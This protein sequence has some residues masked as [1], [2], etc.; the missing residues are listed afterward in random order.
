MKRLSLDLVFG[1]VLALLVTAVPVFAADPID[2]VFDRVPAGFDSWQTL[3]SGATT[4]SFAHDPLPA[5]FFCAGSKAFTGVIKFEGVPLRTSPKGILGTADTLIERLDDAVFD[6]KGVGMTRIRVR[7]LQL[8]SDKINTFCGE[9]TA[10]AQLSSGEQPT[11]PMRMTRV[12]QY[13][14]EFDADLWLNVDI[15]FVRTSDGEARTVTRTLHLPTAKHSVY[16]CWTRTSATTSTSTYTSVYVNQ[17]G[18]ST[19]V[20]VF[21]FDPS[22]CVVGWQCSSRGVCLPVYSWHR[23]FDDENHF[24]YSPC[25]YGYTQQCD[26]NAEAAYLNQLK[27]LRRQGYID[28]DPEVVLERQRHPRG[29]RLLPQMK[30]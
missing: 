19:N 6:E 7:A 13:G 29:E 25:E 21:D 3:G 18:T 12:N 8:V 11:S 15:T 30:Q 5:G 23:A 28:A 20:L 27:E 2:R 14:G 9:W 16:A 1:V 26:T 10:V 22:G 4:Y 24:V 17:P